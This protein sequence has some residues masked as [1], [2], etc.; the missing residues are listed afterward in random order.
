MGILK[1]YLR[2]EAEMRWYDVEP[3]VYM[4]ISMIECAGPNA[5]IEYA[6]YIIKLVKEKDRD[7]T[8]IKNAAKNNV[9]NKYQR[10]Y[11]KNEVLSQ[12]FTYLK[13][14]TKQIQKDVALSVL[15]FKNQHELIP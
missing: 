10:W 12:A 14:T 8:Y 9:T 6:E 13:D 7:L 1:M 3:D 2:E 4:A 5:Q 11:D 15:A